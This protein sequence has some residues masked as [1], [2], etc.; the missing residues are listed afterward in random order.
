MTAFRSKSFFYT[1]GAHTA[2]LTQRSGDQLR[3]E[4]PDSDNLFADGT[5]IPEHQ[6]ACAAGSAPFPGN[7]MSGPIFIED[8]SPGDVIAVQ[9]DTIH[10]TASHGQSLLAPGHGLLAEHELKCGSEA[11]VPTHMYRWAI[12]G[13]NRIAR[14][15]NPIGGDEFSVKLDPFIG[16]IGV[17]P[18]WGQS[19]STLFAGDFGG[20]MDVPLVKPGATLFLPVYAAGALLGLGD[21]HAAQGHGEIMGG[22]I[23]TAGQ[24]D[25][26]LRVIKN[27][28]I[29]TPRLRNRDLIATIASE[30]ELRASVKSAYANLVTWLT[31]GFGMNRFDAY[32]LVS[33]CGSIVMGNIISKSPSVAACIRLDT[34]PANVLHR[35]THLT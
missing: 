12:D 13:A 17:C 14:L 26:T 2:T 16:C 3:I 21:L 22:A 29:E 7:P 23:E 6:R 25:L 27:Q 4:C 1:F 18:K 10:L 31:D 33:Q 8:A 9:I 15:N 20:N 34:L 24:V 28:R 35:E 19:I 11:D 32:N 30:N 5:L